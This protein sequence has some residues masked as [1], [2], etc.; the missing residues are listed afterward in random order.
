M[1]RGFG[2]SRGAAGPAGIVALAIILIIFGL[3]YFNSPT[4]QTSTVQTV[5][6]SDAD[7]FV[8]K[9]I[10]LVNRHNQHELENGF[11]PPYLKE[12]TKPC[13]FPSAKKTV[14]WWYQNNTLLRQD[15]E[16]RTYGDIISTVCRDHPISLASICDCTRILSII[17]TS[18]FSS[19]YDSLFLAAKFCPMITHRL[20][21]SFRIINDLIPER[22][23]EGKYNLTIRL[24]L[25]LPNETAISNMND[26]IQF[27]FRGYNCN[28]SISSPEILL[29]YN[30]E[31]GDKQCNKQVT[32]LL[33]PCNETDIQQCY[34]YGMV[35]SNPICSFSV[36]WNWNN[37]IVNSTDVSQWLVTHRYYQSAWS[38]YFVNL[39]L[40][41]LNNVTYV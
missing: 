18:S 40:A 23:E 13:T 29:I 11:V 32:G 38:L 14:Q 8:E 17:Y 30:N 2:S 26:R 6:K 36:G 3:I 39:N 33:N 31:S 25:T 9:Q 4:S 16:N 37:L 22:V 34:I 15:F 35:C 5:N 12:L 27:L 21:P 10:G 19:Q 20:N 28:F 1:F 41:Q 24:N 7:L